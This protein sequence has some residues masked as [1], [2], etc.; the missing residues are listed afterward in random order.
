MPHSPK[1][2]FEL[3]CRS[4]TSSPTP[5][6]HADFDDDGKAVSLRDLVTRLRFSNAFRVGYIMIIVF[7]ALMVLVAVLTDTMHT[8]WY[9]LLEAVLTLVFT[10]ELATRL[11]IQ[12]WQ[13]FCQSKV[14]IFETTLCAVC[15]LLVLYS[16]SADANTRTEGIVEASI[17]ASRYLAALGRF[18]FFL[19][20]S[21]ANQCSVSHRVEILHAGGYHA[22]AFDYPVKKA[23]SIWEPDEE[24]PVTGELL[25]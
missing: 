23:G 3:E 13:Q 11:L 12:G 10:G 14:N 22:E 19:R 17:L 16:T 9:L 2:D 6:L 7:A 20:N 18:Y 21:P 25:A 15:I 1:H 8:R 4:K 24:D 5:C